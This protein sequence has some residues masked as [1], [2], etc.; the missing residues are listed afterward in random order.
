VSIAGL[1]AIIP[2]N[3][4]FI[5]GAVVFRTGTGLKLAAAT[6]GE[7]VAFEVDDHHPADRSGGASSSSVGPR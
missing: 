7:V 4:R 6:G 1:P 5:D 2:V 3:Y